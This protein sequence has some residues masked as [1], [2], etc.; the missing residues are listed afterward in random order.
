MFQRIILLVGIVGIS[1]FTACSP[2]EE[3]DGNNGNEATANML[4]TVVFVDG[5]AAPNAEVTLYKT[6]EDYNNK[7]NPAT[8]GQTDSSGEVKFE[9]LDLSI[10]YWVAKLGNQDNSNSTFWTGAALKANETFEKT[11][12]IR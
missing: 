9:G 10:Y 12:Q 8:S 1:L 11:T 6:Q 5:S 4:L 7:Q 3:D 2:E